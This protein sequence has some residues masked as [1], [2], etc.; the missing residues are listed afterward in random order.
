MEN[1]SRLTLAL[2]PNCLQVH[3]SEGKKILPPQA[4]CSQQTT[5]EYIL[6]Q[7]RGCGAAWS[8]H[9][10]PPDR[11]QQTHFDQPLQPGAPS[12][13]DVLGIQPSWNSAGLSTLPNFTS[14][15]R[16]LT[17][18]QSKQRHPVS[19]L[20]EHPSSPSSRGWRLSPC[21][22]PEVSLP[23]GEPRCAARSSECSF[24]RLP[25]LNT[26]WKHAPSGFQVAFW[27]RR[28]LPWKTLLEGMRLHAR[29]GH[30]PQKVTDTLRPAQRPPTFV[31]PFPSSDHPTPHCTEGK[32]NLYLLRSFFIKSII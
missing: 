7:D 14:V 10:S 4:D 5:Q 15:E 13:R 19:L 16:G 23:P 8:A 3:F 9:G 18:L 26:G 24:V 17:L 11:R 32:I 29:R 20:G 25:S 31:S 1:Q 27:K 28:G 22:F 30:F 6:A 21:P 12:R 2:Q